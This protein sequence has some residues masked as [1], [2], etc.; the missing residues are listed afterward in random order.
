MASRQGFTQRFLGLETSQEACWGAPNTVNCVRS[1]RID[2]RVSK[3]KPLFKLRKL[4]SGWSRSCF[5]KEIVGWTAA[6]KTSSPVRYPPPRVQFPP[7]DG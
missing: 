4:G 3:M 2:S 1:D 7:A 5:S 6:S